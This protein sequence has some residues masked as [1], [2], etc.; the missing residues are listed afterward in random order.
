LRNSPADR[1]GLAWRAAAGACLVGLVVTGLAGCNRTV[2]NDAKWGEGVPHSQAF[3]R[4]LVVGLSPDANVRCAFENDLAYNL[5]SPTVTAK[6]SCS[7]LGTKEPITRE[8]VER[9]IASFGAD[10]VLATR[11]VDAS[12]KLQEGGTAETRGGGYYKAT[13]L[14][15][16]TNYWGVY[17]VPVVYG[18]FQTAPSLFS[19][20]GTIRIMTSVYETRGATMV[21]SVETKAKNLESREQALVDITPAIAERLR[22]DGLV[23]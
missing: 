21:Y 16:A 11:L 22:R 8:S 13:D 9:G 15:Y 7:V 19:I 5:R 12:S 20:R 4:L 3:S 17:G 18:E 2:S 6:T 1:S 23:R 14:G 10:A